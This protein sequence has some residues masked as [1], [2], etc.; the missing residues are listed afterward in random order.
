MK[1]QVCLQQYVEQTAMVTVFAAS[2]EDAIKV[3]EEKMRSDNFSIDWSE[4]DD[5]I[6]QEAYAVRDSTGEVIWER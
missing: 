3:A 2:I 1:Y 4:G 5:A 6:D